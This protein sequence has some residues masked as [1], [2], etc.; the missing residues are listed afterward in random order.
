[1]KT[2]A[3]HRTDS[4]A[5]EG[6][7]GQAVRKGYERKGERVEPHHDSAQKK[8]PKIITHKLRSKE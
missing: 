5:V 2:D 4:L 6:G 1:M 8:L 7:N 3:N